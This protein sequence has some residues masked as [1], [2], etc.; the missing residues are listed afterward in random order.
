MLTVITG[1]PNKV[2]ECE[3]ILGIALAHEALRLQEIQALDPAPV[4]QHKANTAYATLGRP[5]LVED[6][7]LT[8][9]AWNGLPGALI[10][11]F[12]DSV[13]VGGLCRMLETETNRAATA[14]SVLGY[15]DVH[16]LRTFSGTVHGRIADRPRGEKGFGWDAIFEPHGSRRT[17]A[18]MA[19]TEK[20]SFS[21]RRK[22]LEALNASGLLTH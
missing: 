12:V 2:R 4:V 16:G 10:A 7:S 8:F 15:R 6:T 21:M 22:A 20:D 14:T 17:F 5:V 3:R 13:G 9:E 19:A 1:N 18:E 11:W